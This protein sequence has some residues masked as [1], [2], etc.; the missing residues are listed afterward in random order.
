MSIILK[1]NLL[2]P[3]APPSNKH[4]FAAADAEVIATVGV[5]NG[6]GSQTQI[7][8]QTS[9]A[10]NTEVASDMFQSSRQK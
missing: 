9:S 8:W 6:S 5:M 4:L 1:I 3:R 7:C 2:D 10:Y